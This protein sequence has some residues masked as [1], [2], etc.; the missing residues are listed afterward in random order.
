MVNVHDMWPGI[1]GSFSKYWTTEIPM[2]ERLRSDHARVSR[3]SPP[4]GRDSTMELSSEPA[5][6]RLH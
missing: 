5:V 3:M 1:P 4:Q 6:Q 2:V